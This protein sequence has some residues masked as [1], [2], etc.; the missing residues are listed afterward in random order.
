[1]KKFFSIVVLSLLVMSV[2]AQQI[3]DP[4]VEV[5]PLKGFNSIKISN[6][7]D[8]YLSQGNEEAVAVSADKVAWRNHIKTAVQGGVLKIWYENTG[9]G[10]KMGNR[11]LKAYVSV[12]DLLSLD[13][14][15]ACD[16]V[17]AGR[18]TGGDVRIEM[19]GASDFRG[20]IDFRSLDLKLNGASD[21]NITGKVVSL[22]VDANGASD[23]KGYELET[24]M[25][26]A[27]ASGASDI[28]ITVNKELN[29]RASGAS[30]VYYKGKGVIRDI[31][32]SG[33]SSISKKD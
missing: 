28:K 26:T 5:R 1:M 22:K 24:D 32:S 29:A 6:A 17:I 20:T 27:E 13:A 9:D 33:A 18:M 16:V 19:N 23:L 11:K 14:S 4:N 2:S 31:K 21:A 30:G 8:L 10:F 3:N 12:R 7:I 25:C 15:G